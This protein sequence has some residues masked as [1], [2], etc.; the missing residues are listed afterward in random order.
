M[1]AKPLTP[2]S[3]KN[4]SAC[5]SP[6]TADSSSSLSQSECTSLKKQLFWQYAHP[7]P[8]FIANFKSLIT[9]VNRED[10][11]TEQNEK[12]PFPLLY[13]LPISA[14]DFLPC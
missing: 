13:S 1:V 5:W 9:V 3:F 14:A 6:F 12:L 2:K 4:T 11:Q 8:G 7:F 10:I